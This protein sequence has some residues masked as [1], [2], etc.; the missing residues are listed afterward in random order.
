[1]SLWYIFVCDFSTNLLDNS[2]LLSTWS[3]SLYLRQI[4]VYLLLNSF[5]YHPTLG[6]NHECCCKD[7]ARVAPNWRIRIVCYRFGIGQSRFVYGRASE[8][9]HRLSTYIHHCYCFNQHH[10]LYHFWPAALIF[11]HCFPNGFYPVHPMACRVLS[12]GNRKFSPAR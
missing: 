4:C 8:R 3:N 6:L 5:D 2:S 7:L 11:F 10:F 9:L 1:M 12:H